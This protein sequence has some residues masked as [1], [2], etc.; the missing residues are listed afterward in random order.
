MHLLLYVYLASRL[1]ISHVG[2]EVVET[3]VLLWST[4]TANHRCLL[5]MCVGFCHAIL[6]HAMFMICYAMLCHATP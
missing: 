6:F 3:N 1:S 4:P 2:T 5:L